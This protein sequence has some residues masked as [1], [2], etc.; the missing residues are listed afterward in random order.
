MFE[1][2]FSSEMIKFEITPFCS[3]ICSQDLEMITIEPKQDPYR[4]KPK[5]FIVINSRS[6]P[7]ET[8]SS[9]VTDG[10]LEM[11]VSDEK[12]H[13][14]MLEANVCFKIVPML[15]KDGVFMGNYRTGIVGDD[16]NRKFYSGRKEF[17]PEIHALKKLVHKCKKQGSIKL[18]LDIHGHSI[19]KSSFL[20]GPDPRSFNDQ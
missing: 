19:L 20:F 1:S 9:W 13:Q 4:P 8:S 3:S 10:L 2:L 16:F 5:Q 14:W 15:N 7:G 18:F 6:H 17:F 11:L 12:Y